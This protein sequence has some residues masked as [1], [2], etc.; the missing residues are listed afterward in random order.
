VLE[1]PKRG[2]SKNADIPEAAARGPRL[3]VVVSAANGRKSGG[4]SGETD[5]AD[6]SFAFD[7]EQE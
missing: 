3:N 1:S 4:S 2:T 6:A 7:D 5:G